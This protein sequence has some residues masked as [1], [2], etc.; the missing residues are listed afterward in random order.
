[1]DLIKKILKAILPLKLFDFLKTRKMIASILFNLF[2]AYQYDF[3]L[4]YKFSDIKGNGTSTNLIGEII[5]KYH[6]IEKGLTMP[7][8][9]LGFGKELVL[10]LCEVCEKFILNFGKTDEQLLHAIG[11][12]LEYKKW[13][14][15]Q[16]Y[17]LDAKIVAA[18]QI[19]EGYSTSAKV[20]PQKEFTKA[21]YFDK[22]ESDF[23]QFSNTRSSIRNFT[24][25]DIPLNKILNILELARNTPS[26]C[27]RQSWRTYVYV[28]KDLISK[29]LDIQG[30]NRGFGHLTN[31]LIVVAS[32]LGVFTGLEERNQVYIDGGIYL[33]NL[34]YA[35]HYH[36]IAA[37][38]LNCSNF[39][40]KDRQLRKLCKIK[41][42]EVFIAMVACGIPPES[43]KVAISKRYSLDK[44]NVIV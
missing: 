13:H 36:K 22:V 4:Y 41:E 10:S 9:R 19:L 43:F 14:D 40:E 25:E 32:E 30:G 37:C 16:N 24:A 2:R 5:R 33:M 44:T 35:L 28:D 42:S 39:I 38:I 18:I 17:Q 21:E 23:F 31:K 11:V 20:I 8:T 7:Q 12:L 15:S 29:I 1:M 27:N 3:K 26:A 34:V 6:V